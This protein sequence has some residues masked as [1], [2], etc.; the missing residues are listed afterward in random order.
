[1]EKFT[2]TLAVLVFVLSGKLAAAGPIGAGQYVGC[3]YA[4]WW[5]SCEGCQNTPD[6]CHCDATI[7]RCFTDHKDCFTAFRVYVADPDGFH[8]WRRSAYCYRRFRCNNASGFDGGA[9]AQS[10]ACV[11]SEDYVL[12]GYGYE[13]IMTN[14]CVP[15]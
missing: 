2:P 12:E 15:L 5:T 7:Q 14:W 10:G 1:M 11:K 13:Y 4:Q 9:C 6:N 8:V 3:G